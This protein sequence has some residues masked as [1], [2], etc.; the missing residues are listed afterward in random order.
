M[1]FSFND[2]QM[3]RHWDSRID[4]VLNLGPQNCE[5]KE[6]IQAPKRTLDELQQAFSLYSYYN[7]R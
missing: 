4:C 3:L 5:T 1:L 2:M 7:F 6:I